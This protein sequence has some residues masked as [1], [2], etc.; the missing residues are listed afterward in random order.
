M[1]VS[2]LRVTKVKVGGS[3]KNEVKVVTKRKGGRKY[4]CKWMMSKRTKNKT[5]PS[6]RQNCLVCMRAL[7]KIL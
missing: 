7:M 2:H 1:S 4:L 6:L 5:G 3:G